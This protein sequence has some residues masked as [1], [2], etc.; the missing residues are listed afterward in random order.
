MSSMRRLFVGLAP[1]IDIAEAIHAAVRQCFSAHDAAR[2]RFL[3]PIDLHVTLAFL[4]A[5]DEAALP[6][7]EVELARMF[8]ARRSVALET[9]GSGAFP[10][11]ARPRVL[12]AGIRSPRDRGAE[13][14]ELERAARQAA[15][16][17]GVATAD[18]GDAPFR[19]HTTVARVREH[20]Q[21]GALDRFLALDH[22]SPW[23]AGEVALFESAA[24]GERARVQRYVKLRRIRLT[25]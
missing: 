23:R 9:A 6:R 1:P 25:D 7:L 2:L 16:S 15:V 5:V 22:C 14:G 21:H 4:G 18:S 17:A 11:L 13:L 12:W 24:A 19:P 10:T 8:E 20:L 3:A